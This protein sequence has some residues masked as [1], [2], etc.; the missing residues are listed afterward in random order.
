MTTDPTIGETAGWQ[1]PLPG[2]LHKPAF[3]LFLL[4]LALATAMLVLGIAW[5][6]TA[7]GLDGLLWLLAAATTLVGLARRLPLQNVVAVGLLAAGLGFVALWIGVL[8]DVPFGRREFTEVLGERL[9][10]R[11]PWAMPFLWITLT[12]TCRGV[13]RL[14]LRPW[15]KLTYYGLW[16]MALA[17]GLALLFDLALEPLAHARTWW[18]WETLPRTLTWHTAPW[19]NFLGWILTTLAIYGFSTPWLLNK[20]PVKQ[21]TDWHPLLVWAL[22]LLFLGAGCLRGGAWGAAVIA[23]AGTALATIFA[24]RGGRW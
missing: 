12:V 9:P 10:G 2:R 14:I 7:P 11:V 19:V 8:T 21:P 4:W 22:L 16:V 3:G 6:E 24:I 13:A 17:T 1:N 15:R 18:R 23:L 20:Q 5:P